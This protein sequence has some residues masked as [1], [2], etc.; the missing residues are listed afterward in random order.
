MRAIERCFLT[1]LLSALLVPAG[2]GAEPIAERSSILLP[3]SKTLLL[4]VPGDAHVAGGFPTAIALHPGG[5]YAALLDCG[6]GAQGVE[7]R[8]G[9][10]IV[11]LQTN[12]TTHVA[13]LRFGNGAQQ[14]LFLGLAFNHDGDRLFASVASLTDPTGK[15]HG[16]TGNG[17]AEYVFSQGTVQP[18][19]VLPI[20][21]AMVPAGRRASTVSEAVPLGYA[22]P[23]PAGLAVFASEAGE[24]ILAADNLSDDAVLLDAST[25]ALLGRFELGATEHVPSTYPYGVVVSRDGRRAWVTLWNASEVAEL[26]LRSGNVA[27]RIALAKP[28]AATAPGSHPT[29]MA[30]SSD[31]GLLYVTLSNADRVAVVDT[32]TRTVKGYLSTLLPSQHEAGSWPTAL[33]LSQDGARLFVANSAMNAVGVF[34]VHAPS[35][36]TPLL[37]FIPTEWYPTALAVHGSE[38][39][40]VS[41]KGRSTTPNAYQNGQP[42]PFVGGLLQGS[43]AR[44]NLGTV[45]R[46]LPALTAEVAQ[47][48]RFDAKNSSPFPGR[49]SPIRHV[50]Y[51]IKENRTYDQIL[52][53]LGVGN[54]E[55]SLTLYGREITPNQ[56]QLALRFGVLD[57][58]Y[59]SGE[60]S[61]DGHVW[62]TAAITSD[63][64]EKTWQI[65][66]RG[67]EHAYDY[68]GQVSGEFPLIQGLPDV[69]EP[70]TGYLWADA[71]RHGISYRDYG[72]FVS[73]IW[74]DGKKLPPYLSRY[75][76]L[77]AEQCAHPTIHPGEPLPRWASAP[78]DGKNPWAWQIPIPVLN[79]PTKLELRGHY[80]PYFPS[81][82]VDYPDQL[83]MDLFLDEFRRFDRDLPQLIIVRLPNDHTGGTRPGMPRPAASVADNDLA[84]GRLVD[85]VSHSPRWNDTAI[86]VL[87]DD[88]QN[89][90][91][92]VD[93]HRSIAFVISKYAPKGP[94]PFV[95]H[96]AYTT[97][98]MVHTIEALLGLPPMNAND[99]YAPVLAPLF[100]GAGDQPPY[101]A[102]YRNRDNGLIYQTN[103]ATAVGATLSKAMDFSRPDAADARTLNRILWE[104][105]KVPAKGAAQQ[106]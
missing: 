84:L 102:D 47:S 12:L 33:A 28:V 88:A 40:V 82:H 92:H 63:Y 85:A 79:V 15:K 96:T 7:R 3:S 8:Q 18:L 24:R 64:N 106:R 104:D 95:D 6:Y 72:E 56:H 26:D 20:P 103:A 105:A 36:P 55:P 97:V 38:L 39:L 35:V 14:T 66:Y 44:V 57:N 91:D 67:K 100:S 53:D 58:F 27:S 98:S 5:R 69:D 65:A 80:D 42:E 61:G 10:V 17:I 59:D 11:D 70:A 1:G 45:E 22:V 60:V 74:C 41:G 34:D 68:E 29:A 62:S 87:E 76:E 49:V 32:R 99:A 46:A 54:G 77:Y 73:T 4:P 30:L 13:D 94:A 37:G 83:R 31:G 50:I 51:V 52:G 21:P 2:A 19:R 16:N 71:A 75:A 78:P 9:I 25:G 90:A 101:Q 43:I 86:L 23:Y 93:A 48:N 89:G 81:F